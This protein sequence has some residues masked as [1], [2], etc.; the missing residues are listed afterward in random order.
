MNNLQNSKERSNFFQ[1]FFKFFFFRTNM[2]DKCC[3]PCRD[4]NYATR[5]RPHGRKKCEK[6]P[7]SIF[8][9]NLFFF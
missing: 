4:G 7:V 6:E 5:I 3:V 2:L 8:K 9:K 1:I